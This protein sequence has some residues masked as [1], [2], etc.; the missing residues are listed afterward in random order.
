MIGYELPSRLGLASLARRGCDATT[1]PVPHISAYFPQRSVR[2]GRTVPAGLVELK[3]R[4]LACRSIRCIC[5]PS[6]GSVSDLAPPSCALRSATCIPCYQE[7]GSAGYVRSSWC[8]HATHTTRTQM[9][10]RKLK[11]VEGQVRRG[12]E[13]R[14]RSFKLCSC[15]SM[16]R[17]RS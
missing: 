7:P 15:K 8:R 13:E 17:T 10:R 14:R 11:R 5:S 1:R 4:L 16:M 6:I 9:Q 2:V 3:C 12:E